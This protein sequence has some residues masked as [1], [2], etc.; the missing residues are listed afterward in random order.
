[1]VFGSLGALEKAIRAGWC[2]WTS[3]PVDQG[4][5]S[6]ANPAW[7]QCAATALVVQDLLGGEL[8]MADVREA[9]GT[10]AGVHY[11]NRLMSGM[12]LDL[13]REQFR[14]RQLVGEPR[15]VPRPADVTRGRLPGQYYL[16]SL[17][18]LRRLHASPPADI[19]TAVSVKGVCFRNDGRVLLCRNHR[20][21]W[22][23]PGGRPHV[24]ELFSDALNREI[25]EE[26][27]LEV[28]VDR[29]LDAC[30]FE[31][32]PDMWVDLVAYEC[33]TPIGVSS[34]PISPSDE[35]STVA[36]LDPRGLSD[37]ELPPAYK[38]LIARRGPRSLTGRANS[39]GRAYR[40]LG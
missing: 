17:R 3:D 7:G 30:A 38:R 32:V 6:E 22:E 25:R 35:H 23:L 2:V 10:S 29:L 4:R 15:G 16:L 8:V 14:D 24:G 37:D 28:T 40:R 1:V 11:W 26:T 9:D 31:A 36:F 39:R 33:T 5:W 13:T 19:A 27:G 18:V 12:E 21:E 20:G 34:E